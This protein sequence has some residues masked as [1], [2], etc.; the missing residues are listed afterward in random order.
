MI[1]IPK[2]KQDIIDDYFK[3]AKS[4]YITFLNDL[5]TNGLATNLISYVSDP[6]TGNYMDDKLRE[7]IVGNRLSLQNIINI[8]NGLGKNDYSKKLLSD[9][10]RTKEY[11]LLSENINVNICPYCNRTYIHALKYR[12]IKPEY[13]HYY[14]HKSYSYLAISLFNLVPCCSLC[15]KMKGDADPK[16]DNIIYPYEEEFGDDV[17]FDLKYKTP[18]DLLCNK[19]R[20]VVEIEHKPYLP[21]PAWFDNSVDTIFKLKD[22]YQ[23]HEDYIKSIIE[24]TRIY[25]NN[26]INSIFNSFSWL[27][28]DGIESLK[29]VLYA[30][31]AAKDLW[32]T[33]ILSKLT[34]DIVKR[35]E[36]R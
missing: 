20:I 17:Y 24:L 3:A 2:V 28:K 12:K 8:A 36:K 1:L 25:G 13:D 21:K 32:H 22:F 18:L 26:R 34:F 30:N 23:K 16:N 6:T 7:I 4:F 14:P 19:R 35:F 9:F 31:Y 5:K 11:R 27:H 33:K 10:G 15:N 29:S